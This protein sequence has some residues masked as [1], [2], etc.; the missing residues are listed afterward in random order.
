[1]SLAQLSGR[2]SRGTT[3]LHDG[4]AAR[5]QG[6]RGDS[7][8]PSILLNL[9]TQHTLQ[10]CMLNFG[11]GAR[12]MM[13]ADRKRRVETM[14]GRIYLTKFDSERSI[15]ANDCP[16]ASGTN[17]QDLVLRGCEWASCHSYQNCTSDQIRSDIGLRCK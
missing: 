6:D 1:M 13:R 10:Y 2:A 9:M 11:S 3:I 15:I 16:Q 7:D 5:V 14:R 4:C 17:T 12:K 8:R